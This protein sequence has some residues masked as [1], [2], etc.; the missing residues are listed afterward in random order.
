MRLDH[1]AVEPG[2]T[3]CGSLVAAQQP[4]DVGVDFAGQDSLH[5][6]DRL[7]VRD[8][9]PVDEHRFQTGGLHGAADLRPTTV[10]HH[11]PDPDRGQQG[12]ITGEAVPQRC[13]HHG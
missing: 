8:P 4:N 2:E 13:V 1:P 10:H 11:G 9:Q 5:H 7:V 3:H 12:D 6:A